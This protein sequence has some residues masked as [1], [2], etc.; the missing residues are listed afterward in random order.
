MSQKLEN[1]LSAPSVSNAAPERS[2]NGATGSS[3]SPRGKS[4]QRVSTDPVGTIPMKVHKRIVVCCDG[5]VVLHLKR[6]LHHNSTGCRTWKDGII[7]KERWKYTN[8][9]VCYLLL[10]CSIQFNAFSRGLREQLST[11]MRDSRSACQIVGVPTPQTAHTSSSQPPIHQVVF[12][13]SGIGTDESLQSK[14]L[15]GIENEYL[16]RCCDTKLSL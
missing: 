1:S 12:Y 7:M 9:I 3:P 13:Q 14:L 4:P 11:S 15:E 6:L 2:S 16:M 10:R 5:C 8:L